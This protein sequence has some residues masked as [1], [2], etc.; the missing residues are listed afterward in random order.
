MNSPTSPLSDRP[1]RDDPLFWFSQSLDGRLTDAERAKLDEA[2]A[3]SPAL[4][5]QAAELA[6]IHDLMA[7]SGEALP[8]IDSP[9]FV[10]LATASATT[11]RAEESDQVDRWLEAFSKSKPEVDSDAFVRS[12]LAKTV[13]VSV[14]RTLGP[15]WLSRYRSLAVAASLLVAL[16]GYMGY[17]ATRDRDDRPTGRSIVKY[18]R[19]PAPELGS[20][21]AAGTRSNVIAFAMSE[22]V[23]SGGPVRRDRVEIIVVG[24]EDVDGWSD[25]GPPL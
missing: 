18:D 10:Q 2:L 16:T 4:R 1:D 20:A 14:R 21:S 17:R 6:W 22:S 3:G 25:S 12:V 23:R 13:A 9:A 8:D 7:G 24:A 5:A 15:R 11:P 19:W